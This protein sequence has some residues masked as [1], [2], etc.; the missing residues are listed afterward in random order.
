MPKDLLS[1]GCASMLGRYSKN[2]SVSILKHALYSGIVHFD[3]ARSYGYGEAEKVLGN[4][5]KGNEHIKISSKFGVLPSRKS[6]VFSFAK[7]FVRPFIK[8]TIPNSLSMDYENNTIIDVNL[9][10]NSLNTTLKSLKVDSI[11]N[12]FIHEPKAS[13]ILDEQLTDSLN[14]LKGEGII[15]NWG[16]SGYQD[17]LRKIQVAPKNHNVPL[18]QSSMC[19]LDALDSYD[20]QF[21]SIFSPYHRGFVLNILASF[22]EKKMFRKQFEEIAN[23]DWLSYSPAFWAIFL[24][25]IL[26][27]KRI[28]TATKNK[29]S[30]DECISAINNP[31]KL[32]K[33]TA[34]KLIKIINQEY[35]NTLGA[36]N[37]E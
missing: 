26:T 22:E 32:E 28:V 29:K 13:F 37:D 17:T 20:F 10:R 5:L 23:V 12:L 24:L 36:K 21:D 1:L 16:I 30:L 7:P 35:K 2:E 6:K 18:Y 27:N 3:V 8:K 25:S 4:V 9:M 11:H 31:M 14:E 34:L 19:I 15:N 33:Q